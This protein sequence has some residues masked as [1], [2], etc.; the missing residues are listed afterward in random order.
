MFAIFSA[1][2]MIDYNAAYKNFLTNLKL[3]FTPENISKI[4]IHKFPIPYL[5]I[6]S[7]KQDGKM[8]LQDLEIKFSLLS[9]IK[10][11]PEISSLK[12]NTLKLHILN[13]DFSIV[14]HDKLIADLINKDDTKISVNV[15]NL[16]LLD[17]NN[18][19]N[20]IIKGFEILE[21][22]NFKG[23]F[24]D[25]GEF[26]GSFTKNAN[27]VNFQF[28]LG[29]EDYNFYLSESYKDSKLSQGSIKAQIKNLPN[30]IQHGS[31]EISSIFSKMNQ[32]EII[33]IKFD[34]IPSDSSLTFENLSMVSNSIN[35][36]GSVII[37]KAS[38]IPNIINLNFSKIDTNSLLDPQRS[39]SI[40]EYKTTNRF[41]FADKLLQ[42][43]ISIDK[44][45]LK[46]RESLNNVKILSTLELGKFFI[47]DFSGKIDSGGEFRLSGEISQNDF[48]SV[49]TGAINLQHSNLNNILTSFGYQKSKVERVTPFTLS[50]D[51][52]IT[53]IDM[54]LQ[55]ILLKTDNVKMTGNISSK[56]IGSTPRIQT[57]L[58]FSSIDLAKPD[59]PIISP[60]LAFAK[61]LTKDMK[62]NQYLSKFVP[63]RS[64][65]Y[66]GNFNIT[67]NDLV[68]N[69]S[70]LGKVN[71]LMN[72]SPGQVRINNLYINNGIDYLSTNIS[73]QATG[74]KPTLDVVIND[75]SL[76]VDF[77][78][79]QSLLSARNAL[80]NE[81]RVDK[82]LFK[83]DCSLSKIYQNNLEFSNIRFS[84]E[85]DNIL[86]KITN[87]EANVLSGN[88]KAEGS[89]LLEPNTW[90][91]VYAL[92]SFSLEDLSNNLPRGLLNTVGVGSINGL[93][94]T[95]GDSLEKILYNLYSKSSILLKNTK[96]N[97][98]SID[99]FTKYVVSTDYNNEDFQ[100]NLTNGLLT[101]QTAILNLETNAELSK[102]IVT[103]KDLNFKTESTSCAAAAS[104]NIYNFGIN[105][106]S[107]FSFYP[108]D[109]ISR[110]SNK[111]SEPLK[112]GLKLA[113]TIFSVEKIPDTEELIKSL[114][115]MSLKSHSLEPS[116]YIKTNSLN[117]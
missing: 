45:L 55:N 15:S 106:A 19:A 38:N 52:K 29:N 115:N 7:I 41:T 63:I 35:S 50:S 40:R 102:G 70:T 90:N 66:I 117:K 36:T 23:T 37:N 81:F 53:L 101:G 73:L 1:L 27:K 3:E 94:S 10:F 113:G 14:N 44:V 71:L 18:T 100:T 22:S 77:L 88:L 79:P 87:L 82:V 111:N 104:I 95:N 75:G 86:F 80:V 11:K 85:N 24:V 92:N 108:L 110:V 51:L 112:L 6:E 8:E 67:F 72:V 4:Q 68:Y 91:F 54:Y 32:K 39:S 16:I 26:T 69:D 98:F 31:P 96:I 56:F 48:R 97:N 105:A 62:D 74:L 5:Q 17:R 78:N 13:D 114:H 28:N 89:I 9:L 99:D 76:H 2:L 84:T 61:S 83:L 57:S 47:K 43:N 25:I 33:E 65:E 12:I 64:L 103:L 20:L 42:T 59:Y 30:L 34:I 58:E 93:F 49:F 21:S 107:I 116:S 109:K 46:D 60:V